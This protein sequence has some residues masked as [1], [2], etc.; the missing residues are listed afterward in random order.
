MDVDGHDDR[1][2]LPLSS[3]PDSLLERLMQAQT[4]PEGSPIRLPGEAAARK[5]GLSESL[6][7][8]IRAHRGDI[9]A[10]LR[11]MPGLMS[12][13]QKLASDGKT[14]RVLVTRENLHLL[15][16]NAQ[17]VVKPWLRDA[18]G[19]FV[20]NVDLVRVPPDLAGALTSVTLQAALTEISARIE[21]VVRGVRELDALMRLANQGAVQGA[22]DAVTE[23]GALSNSSERRAQTLTACIQLRRELGMIAGQMKANI[24]RMPH[25][26]TSLRDGFR[27]S[28]IDDAKVAYDRVRADFAVLAEGLRRLVT[29]YIELG[30]HEAARMAFTGICERLGEADLRTAADRSRL[31]PY[32]AEEGGP[33]RPFQAF[34]SGM[35][36]VTARLRSL[37][38]GQAPSIE[39][40]FTAAELNR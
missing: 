40:D 6:L 3:F 5:A 25:E 4:G 24:V 26:K 31:L 33:E 21:V 11:Q 14:Y 1:F 30:E 18:K 22:V 38:D 23:A 27:G 36:V 8:A 20:E 17:G 15:A 34:L 29:A 10:V 35:P 32:R 13:A 19:R 2:L 12:A 7:S 39:L 9:L 37:G 16:E 28:G